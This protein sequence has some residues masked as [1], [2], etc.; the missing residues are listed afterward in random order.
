MRVGGS[1]ARARRA[2]AIFPVRLRVGPGG[3]A[4]V[5]QIYGRITE[6]QTSQWQ[7][8]KLAAEGKDVINPASSCV[9]TTA[10]RLLCPGPP[11]R[12]SKWARV[13]GWWDPAEKRSFAVTVLYGCGLC[14]TEYVSVSV[15]PLLI[16]LW[17]RLTYGRP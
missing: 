9:P 14:L 11:G 12:A 2:T 16:L 5:G 8:Q 6:G 4:V 1:D 3:L 13:A 7:K 17:E 15:S 10:R